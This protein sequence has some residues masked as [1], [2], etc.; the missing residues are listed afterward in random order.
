MFAFHSITGMLPLKK[1]SIRTHLVCLLF[2]INTPLAFSQWE[3]ISPEIQ[4][5]DLVN[6]SIRDVHFISEDTGF[7]VGSFNVTALILRTKN[8]GISWDTTKLADF[9]V[10]YPNNTA[11]YTIDFPNNDSVGYISCNGDVLKTTN[12][13]DSWFSLDI[14]NYMDITT[15][16]RAMQFI[17]KD[18]GY[19]AFQDGGSEF[20]RT[21][22]GGITWEND[23]TMP[24]GIRNFSKYNDIIMGMSSA[25]WIMLDNQNIEWTYN[26][27]TIPIIGNQHLVQA[28]YYENRI[29]IIGET[30]TG[31]QYLYSDDMGATWKY[32]RLSFNGLF[33]IQMIDENI[34][35]ISGS[36]PGTIKTFDGG[37][38]WWFMEVDNLGTNMYTN[39]QNFHMV[40]DSVGYAVTTSGIY[41]TTNG[42]GTPQI[43]IEELLTVDE[44]TSNNLMV[45]PSPFTTTLNLSFNQLTKGKISIFDVAGKLV[46]TEIVSNSN[47]ITIN[48]SQFTKGVYFYKLVDTN[49]GLSVVNGSVVKQ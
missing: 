43:L 12:Y 21:L 23:P 33:D 18:T 35:Y 9:V 22:D 25:T 19:I 37:E 6:Y 1:T 17:N 46:H 30:W 11:G 29:I 47:S 8:A 10:N 13:G 41:K 32:K 38:T 39:F 16:W 4:Q 24:Y 3:L 27:L 5:N 2:I 48:T 31:T 49:T 20:L 15:R 36:F 34:G 44:N 26:D 40:N 28:V 45:Y 7:V 14:N 42:A